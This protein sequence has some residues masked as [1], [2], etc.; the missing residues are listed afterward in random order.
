M[1]RRA[2]RLTAAVLVVCTGLFI[3]FVLNSKNP[4][5]NPCIRAVWKLG[6]QV[7][8]T[9]PQTYL[10]FDEEK[11][12][13]GIYLDSER[14]FDVLQTQPEILAWFENWNGKVATGKLKYCGLKHRA[15]PFITWQPKDIPLEDIAEGKYDRYLTNYFELIAALCPQ[16]D[17][18]IRFAHEM[19]MRPRY[20][21]NW[22]SWQGTDTADAFRAAWIHVVRLGRR[23]CPNVKWVWSPNRADAYTEK[24]YPGDEYVDYVGVSLNHAANREA[25]YGT[26]SDFYEQEA[27]RAELEQYGKKI[28]ISEVSFAEV[29]GEKKKIYLQ[30]IFDYYLQDPNIVCAVFFNTSGTKD[31]IYN[32][33][34]YPEYMQVFY[35]GL[36][37]LRE[38]P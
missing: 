8:H 27:T 9:E 37:K 1:K 3:F 18:L 26:F 29:G 30:S 13:I 6:N 10:A 22:Y 12:N 35:D 23:L 36:R 31:T 16:N 2:S 14:A 21:K 25:K 19:D 7:L 28:F 17:V 20:E 4:L 11:K 15:I 5:L 38:T 33:S 32:I 24:Y 34:D